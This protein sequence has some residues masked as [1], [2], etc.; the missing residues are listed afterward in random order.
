M[1][2]ITAETLRRELNYDPDT[3]VFT[4]R[5]ARGGQKVGDVAGWLGQNGYRYINVAG[6]K[7]TAHSLAWLHVYG[8]WPS[9]KLDHRNRDRLDNRI[10]NLREASNALNALNSGLRNDNTTGH[11]GIYWFPRTAKWMACV[12]DNG[13]Q[14]HLGYFATKE[15]AIAARHAAMA[16]RGTADEGGLSGSS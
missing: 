13:R 16:A 15:Q 12:F 2:K 9:L 10:A 7:Y 14:V 8:V 3:G 4:R 6:G 1:E 11:R 5:I